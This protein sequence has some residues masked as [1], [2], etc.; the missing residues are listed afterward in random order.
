MSDG[1][2]TNYFRLWSRI[3][4]TELETFCRDHDRLY[5]DAC[6]SGD[7][8][9]VTRAWY[10]SMAPLISAAYGPSWHFVPPARRGQQREE[11]QRQLHEHIAAI[12][13]LEQGKHA[14]DIGCGVGGA[15]RNVARR[16]GANVTGIAL[17]DDEIELNNRI[18]RNEAIEDLCKATRGDALDM[19]FEDESFDAAYAI[20]ALKYFPEPVAV[21]AEVARTLRPGGLFASYDLLRSDRFD[22]NDP[23]HAALVGRFEYATA[24][25]PLA[26]KKRLREQA[27]RVGLELVSDGRFEGNLPWYQCFVENPL[28]PWLVRSRAMRRFVHT[29]EKVRLLP[30]GFARFEETFISGNVSAIIEAGRSGLLDGASLMLWRR[31]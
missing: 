29:A 21:L 16:S 10:G 6:R 25:P 12:L 26:T 30:R 3:R 20:Y 19:P 22:E 5:R 23:R 13:R 9:T 2:V 27:Q 4:S 7:Y 24:M 8:A 14:L 17:G 1:L 28:L 11:A 18:S 15:M 31:V